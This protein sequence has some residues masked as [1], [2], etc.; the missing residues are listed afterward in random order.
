MPNLAAQ[1]SAAAAAPAGGAPSEDEA[2]SLENILERSRRKWE[3]GDTKGKG[4][5]KGKSGVRSKGNMAFRPNMSAARSTS[6][7]LKK[8]REAKV[9][10]DASTAKPSVKRAHGVE[11]CDAG[12]SK[13]EEE[14][15]EFESKPQQ[16]EVEDDDQEHP[17]VRLPLQDSQRLY[18]R[19]TVIDDP[20]ASAPARVE[21]EHTEAELRKT[22]LLDREP[23]LLFVQLPSILPKRGDW[24][25]PSID[26][27]Q[28][29]EERP[30]EAGMKDKLAGE[31][32]YSANMNKMASGMIG[33]LKVRRSGKMTLVVG[34]IEYTVEPGLDCSFSQQV[35]AVDV[36][37]GTQSCH[38]LGAVA[39]RLVCSVNVDSLLK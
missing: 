39:D 21:K 28:I 12:S 19:T 33:K 29:D 2:E 1:R 16:D 3:Q 14:V 23:G 11:D 8:E 32:E 17:P 31:P 18:Q 38:N 7:G 36:T 26:S 4:K 9:A 22:T 15:L 34:D 27:L 37:P 30:V 24:I 35:L 25:G 20:E 6:T 5:G 10:G 13:K